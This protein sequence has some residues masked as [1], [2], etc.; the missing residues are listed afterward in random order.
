MSTT[1]LPAFWEMKIDPSSGKPFFIDH[2]NR[3][4][5]WID[6]RTTVGKCR[7]SPDKIRI[8]LMILYRFYKQHFVMYNPT[9]FVDAMLNGI[10]PVIPQ[11]K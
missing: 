9:K 10:R 5:T 7:L 3:V 1:G 2:R 6:P 11:F 8:F 4:T